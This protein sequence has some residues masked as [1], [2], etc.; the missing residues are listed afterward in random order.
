MGTS[1]YQFILDK[2][3]EYLSN[4]L[5]TTRKSLLDITIESGF[6]DVRNAYRL[7][8]KNTGYTPLSF[9][10]KFSKIDK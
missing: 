10:K 5:L 7:F 6:N 3:I 2:K 4:E 8:K 1:I 9:R